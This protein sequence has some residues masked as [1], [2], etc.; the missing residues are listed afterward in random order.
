[1]MDYMHY[2]PRTL[3]ELLAAEP[4]PDMDLFAQI[5]ESVTQ[6]EGAKTQ[7]TGCG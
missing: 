4:M 7:Q 5:E 6:F 2:T 3:T 1:M